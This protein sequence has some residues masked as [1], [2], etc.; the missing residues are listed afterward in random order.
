MIFWK[1]INRQLKDG[2]HVIL[3]YVLSSDGSSP[4]RQGFKMFVS[5]TGSI[6]GSIG[7]G[8]MEHKLVEL[9]R[10]LLTQSKIAPFIRHQI[11]QADAAIDKSGMICSGSQ[12]IAFYRLTDK[13]CSLISEVEKSISDG[14]YGVLSLDSAG[15]RFYNGLS[16]VKKYSLDLSTDEKWCLKED[17][18]WQPRLHIVGGGHVGLALS[19][20]SSL[21]GFDVTVYDDRVDLNT[22]EMNSYARCV[23]VENYSQM[24]NIILSGEEQFVVIM[25]FG[26]RTDLEIL[27][28]LI[29]N[30]Y[31]YIGMMGSTHKTKQLMIQLEELGVSREELSKVH[32]PI[33]IPI[34]SKTPEEI[35]I[36]VLAEMIQVK[37]KDQI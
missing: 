16:L 15:I 21:A 9:C 4:G 37:N 10:S 29:K 36:S 24:G 30:D 31:Q 25:S 13:D 20:F 1:E 22:F 18:G 33:G 19:K 11:H 34:A 7:G 2:H 35:A 12:T 5:T 17:I 6:H 28:S 26:F 23:K 14:S 3:M 32:A 27:R 8:I